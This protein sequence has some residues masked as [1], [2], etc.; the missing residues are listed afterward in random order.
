[1]DDVITVLEVR[2]YVLNVVD[3]EWSFDKFYGLFQG[4]VNLFQSFIGG[5]GINF[6]IKISI[7]L[8]IVIYII[9]ENFS[10]YLRD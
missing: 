6:V 10:M 7:S 3:I 5:G 9:I 2:G 8:F 1:M 4:R